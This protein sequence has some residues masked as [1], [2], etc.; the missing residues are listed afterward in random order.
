MADWENDR[1]SQFTRQW[2]DDNARDDRIRAAGG[3]I[4][5]AGPSSYSGKG[6][7]GNIWSWSIGLGVVGALAS[8]TAGY[9]DPLLF[10]GFCFIAVFLIVAGLGL[11]LMFLAALFTGQ[12]FRFG[13][14][15]AEAGATA[16]IETSE[17]RFSEAPA[18]R[19]TR[20]APSVFKAITAG[21]AIGAAAGVAI[22]A[23]AG[24]D[25]AAW[26]GVVRI[27]PI[28]LGLGAAVGVI[29]RLAFSR[30]ATQT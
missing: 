23:M 15:A 3:G 5:F 4:N 17:G 13:G 27:A 6:G 24:P 26:E 12:L 18:Q 10:A 20:R 14:A 8:F 21:G 16:A 25:I 1:P 7:G 28:G 22:A 30:R 19:P 11:A 2:L 9:P 29:R